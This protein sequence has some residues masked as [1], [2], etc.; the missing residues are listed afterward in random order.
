MALTTTIQRHTWL[1]CLGVLFNF[2]PGFVS[3]VVLSHFWRLQHKG[4]TFCRWMRLMIHSNTTK[5]NERIHF[6]KLCRF[7]THRAFFT[8]RQAWTWNF[9]GQR[10]LWVRGS[11]FPQTLEDDSLFTAGTA[12]G[13]L[14]PFSWDCKVVDRY[15]RSD[16]TLGSEMHRNTRKCTEQTDLN[17]LIFVKHS[18]SCVCYS[19]AACFFFVS[20]R[21]QC[22][23]RPSLTMHSGNTPSH[24]HSTSVVAAFLPV[25]SP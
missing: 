21:V 17:F 16:L 15:S 8:R 5:R 11:L 20:V 9:L 7:R 6:Q 23:A 10:H 1:V 3:G 19:A 18:S 22:T 12:S 24:H 2:S 4:I 25:E 14:T 13:L